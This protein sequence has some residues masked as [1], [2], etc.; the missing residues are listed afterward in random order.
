M[1]PWYEKPYPGGAMVKV[2]GFPRK[3]DWQKKTKPG[4]DVTAYQRTYRAPA[5]GSGANSPTITPTNSRAASPKPTTKFFGAA[6][7]ACNTIDGR[8][9]GFRDYRQR[10]V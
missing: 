7:P 4:P 10:H 9:P 5:A 2:K 1:A 8:R 6:S 3:L